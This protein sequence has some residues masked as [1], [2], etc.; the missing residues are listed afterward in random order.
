[1]KAI[2]FYCSGCAGNNRAGHLHTAAVLHN[3][4]VALEMYPAARHHIDG[5]L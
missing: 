5:V 4:V 3:A 2:T 1:M